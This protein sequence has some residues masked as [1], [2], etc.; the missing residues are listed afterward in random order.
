M[1]FWGS[2]GEVNGLALEQ[3]LSNFLFSIFITCN[4]VFTY[5]WMYIHIFLLKSSFFIFKFY[6]WEKQ[7]YS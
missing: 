3:V 6:S 4:C 2:V 7:I 1:V 5:A